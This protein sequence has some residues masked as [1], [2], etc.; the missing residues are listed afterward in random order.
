MK[1][2]NKYGEVVD[3][4]DDPHFKSLL[5][6]LE[7]TPVVEATYS[8]PETPSGKAESATSPEHQISVFESLLHQVPVDL[9]SADEVALFIS[10]LP[11]FDKFSEADAMDFLLYREE[12][13]EKT[14]IGR[15][16]V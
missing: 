9:T 5:K 3:I 8:E 1:V 15:A 13:Q 16:H 2:R 7:L 14:K 4:P 6:N 10:D 11:G 12:K